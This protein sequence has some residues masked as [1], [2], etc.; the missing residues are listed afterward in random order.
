MP[1]REEFRQRLATE[2]GYAST[3]M[4]EAQPARKLFYFSA[5]FGEASRILNWEWDSDLVLIHAVTRH[6]YNQIIGA[7]QTTHEILP[8]DWETI[9][10][11]LTQNASDLSTY[12]EKEGN[13]DSK[14]EL[15]QT[16]CSLA[17]IAYV[18]SGNG[19]Y[20]YEKGLLKL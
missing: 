10:E 17:E 11:K 9:Y 14:E 19:I 3:K 18:V 12:F 7:I 2:Y 20:L 13:K 1:L 6:T 8:S 4:K 5:F 15:Y 16:L